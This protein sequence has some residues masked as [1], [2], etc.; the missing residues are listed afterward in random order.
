MNRDSVDWSGYLPAV[1]T[2]FTED[3]ELDLAAW[4]EQLDWLLAERMDGI[5]VAGTTG[6]WFSL[7]EPERAELFRTAADQA[8]GRVPVL[9]GATAYTPGE[10]IRHAT[11][12]RAAGLSGVLLTPPPY[13]VPSRREIVAFYRTV[14]AAVDIPICVYNW[15][16]GTGVDLDVALLTELA[17]IDTVVA[18]K[19]S[20]PDFGSFVRGLIA[21]GERVRYFGIPTN[22]TG[23]AL[24]TKLG[25]DGLMGAGGVL[26]ADHPGF[27]RAVAAG[28]LDTAR[29]LGARDRVLMDA[30]FGA[31]Y[32]ARFGNAP[33]ILKYA[34]RRRGVPGGHVRPPLLP[35]TADEQ[36]RVADTLDS[37]GL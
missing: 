17:G 8:A 25:G 22:D 11:A 20:T 19:N 36:K 2:P 12:A 35:L 33:A 3:G 4:R 34:L 31:D 37:L 13:L 30:W 5:I 10:A 32:G 21:L 24:L 29:Q 23:I 28:D 26:G 16:R 15:P 18:V 7:S 14:S 9:G 27:F 6:E 1:T